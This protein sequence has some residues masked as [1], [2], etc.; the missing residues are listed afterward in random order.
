MPLL[1]AHETHIS[2]MCCF[3]GLRPLLCEQPSGMLVFITVCEC[4][5]NHQQLMV[6]KVVVVVVKNK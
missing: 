2:V 5:Y 3:V 6:V 1:L 4:G